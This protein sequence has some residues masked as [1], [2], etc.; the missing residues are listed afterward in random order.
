MANELRKVFEADGTPSSGI[1]N[2]GANAH[3]PGDLGNR[4]TELVFISMIWVSYN[5]SG[6]GILGHAFNMFYRLLTGGT[7]LHYNIGGR[8]TFLLE[9]GTAVDDEMF[10]MWPTVLPPNEGESDLVWGLRIKQKLMDVYMKYGYKPYIG[11][12]MGRVID[13]QDCDAGDKLLATPDPPPLAPGGQTPCS[14]LAREEPSSAPG[15]PS[16]QAQTDQETEDYIPL[17][18]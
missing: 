3:I 16:A 10:R 15:T 4:G 9:P 8:V 11:R 2:Y 6:N 18:S 1:N 14:S 17:S 5:Y 12:I 7:L 13:P